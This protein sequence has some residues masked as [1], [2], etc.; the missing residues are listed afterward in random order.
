MKIKDK[1]TFRISP[2]GFIR[3]ECE[4]VFLDI[5]DKYNPGLKEIDNFSHIQVF[6]WFNKFDSERYRNI[7][8][9]NPPYE[10]PETGVFACRSPIRPNPI[11]LTT[12]KILEV[13]LENGLIYINDIDA[14]SDSPIIDLKGYFPVCDRVREF[15]VPKWASD[16][17]EW[18]PDEG[19][20]PEK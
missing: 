4:K 17:P 9:C 5:K 20:S 11:A 7:L 12:V 13:D 10:A 3:R 14:D 19:L 1:E 6:W 8:L 15:H 16:W 18:Y 2:I